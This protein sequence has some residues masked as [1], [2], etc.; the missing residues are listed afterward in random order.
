MLSNAHR[1]NES[2]ISKMQSNT[3]LYQPNY[4]MS[5]NPESQTKMRDST[6][7]ALSSDRKP[8]DPVTM[9][10]KMPSLTQELSK[11]E[12]PPEGS[13]SMNTDERN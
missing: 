1:R 13:K 3:D 11:I 6:M 5:D 8:A 2:P 10:I 7:N 4:L 9:Q 12:A